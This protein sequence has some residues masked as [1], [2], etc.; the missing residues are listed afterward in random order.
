MDRKIGKHAF[1][2]ACFG[3]LLFISLGRSPASAVGPHDAL[4]SY[5]GSK[6]CMPCHSGKAEEVFGS[7]HYQLKGPTPYVPNLGGQIVGKLG[8]INDYCTY[9]DIN[10]LFEMTNLSAQ[11]V[12]VGCSVCHVGLGKKPAKG[13]T[14]AQLEN[15]DCLICHSDIY[16]RVGARVSGILK[17]VPDP[18]IDIRAALAD[19]QMPSQAA[20]LSRCHANAGGG[21]GVKQGDI[22]PLLDPPRTL[23]VHMSSQGAGLKCR[24]C[25]TAKNHHIA[26]RGNDIRETDLD[27]KV[28]CTNC[29]ASVPHT[30]RYINKHI[31]RVH[32]TVCHIPA[33]ARNL[34]TETYRDWSRSAP[35]LASNRYEPIR[36]KGVNLTPVYKFFNGSSYFYKFGDPLTLSP[37]GTFVLSGPL[38]NIR[39]PK[40]KI[41]AFKLHRSKMAYDQGGTRLIPIKSRVMWQT[42]NVD[43]AIRQGIL[44]VGW[45][46]AGYKFATSSRY[47]SLY[48]QVA[49]KENALACGACHPNTG[50][51]KF[52]QLGYTPKTT[53]NNLPLCASCHSKETAN[54]FEIHRKHV[55][56]KNFS[57][58]ICHN[59]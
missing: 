51:V 19:I 32:C 56:D 49:P 21:S 35:D 15:I 40:A 55:D 13:M 29:H 17:F 2:L 37:T 44:S 34:P 23:D 12:I 43:Q 22:D 39:D 16:K 48:H 46:D 18:T 57:C 38:G 4:T 50:R 3:F 9:P 54:F 11:K 8:G 52:Q 53:Y 5:E 36:A 7:A 27:A 10:W 25:H 33:Y 14:Q 24:D 1:Q 20:C 45:P 58:S 59:F 30:D 31:N 41:N 42:G 47:L 28:D 6:T 26:G